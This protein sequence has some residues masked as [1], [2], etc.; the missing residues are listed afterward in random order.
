M[1]FFEDIY[2]MKNGSGFIVRSYRNDW[3]NLY[4]CGWDGK[5]MQQLTDFSFMVTDIDRVDEETKVIYF[6]A[7]GKESTEKHLFRVGL[8]GKNLIQITA[9][10]GTHTVSISPKGNY[11]VDTWSSIASPGSI[12]LLDKKARVIREI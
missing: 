7:T 1:E 3:Q 10:E 2:V 9:G 4:Y 8:D 11:M 12:V 5:Q 6:Y